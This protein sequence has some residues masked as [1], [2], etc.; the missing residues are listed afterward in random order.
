VAIETPIAPI[1]LGAAAQLS[2]SARLC[3]ASNRWAIFCPA[4]GDTMPHARQNLSRFDF[5]SALQFQHW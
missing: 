5:N 2:L 3:L 4:N 1:K